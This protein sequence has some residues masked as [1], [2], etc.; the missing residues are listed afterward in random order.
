MKMRKIILHLGYL[1]ASLLL[2]GCTAAL[3]AGGVAAGAGTVAYVNGNLEANL[4]ESVGDLYAASL[5]A[6]DELEIKVISAKRD[7]LT[8]EIVGRDAQDK[9]VEID[10]KRT[11]AD[12]A[13]LSIR[14]GFW[15]DKIKSQAIYDKIKA[16]L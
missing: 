5:D 15:G 13:E 7:K 2:T 8:A 10:V 16:N 6:M 12:M 9:K 4:D 1:A 11:E 14:V 3:V